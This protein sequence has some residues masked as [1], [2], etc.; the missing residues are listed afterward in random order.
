MSTLSQLYN[1]CE[2]FSVTTT[3]PISPPKKS[4]WRACP[5]WLVTTLTVSALTAGV[6]GT[7]L[8][9]FLHSKPFQKRQFSAEEAA[10]FNKEERIS[11]LAAGLP[12]LTRPVNILVLGTIVLSSD[13]P[14]LANPDDRYFRQIGSDLDGHSDAILLIRFD[15]V[16]QKIAAISIPR[17]TLTLV[18]DLGMTK[19]NTANFVGGAPLAARTVSKLLGGVPIDRYVRVNVQ[20]FN[21][22][23]DALGGVEVYVPK[24]LKYQDD[25]Q[26]LYIN[27]KAGKQVLNGDKAVQ[28]MRF[29]QDDLGDIGRV[30]RQQAFI[31][32]LIEQKLHIETVAKIPEILNILHDNLDTNLTVEEMLALGSFAAKIGRKDTRLLMLPGR[33][34]THEYHLSYWLVNEQAVARMMHEHFDNLIADPKALQP[35][36]LQNLRLAVQDSLGDPQRI[37]ALQNQ[38]MQLGYSQVQSMDNPELPVLPK[39]QIIAQNGDRTSAEAIQ[40][41]LGIGEVVVESTGYIYSD[42]TIRLGKDWQPSP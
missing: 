13:R 19:I 25:S 29:R 35:T 24:D 4:P 10:A 27:L 2:G 22:L 14:A 40:K 12:D 20:G 17:D 8:A 1:W 16:K 36:N 26:R 42:V 3:P 5:K 7:G 6:L 28:Y 34:S 31:R 9:F 15:P 39:T 23:I 11:A 30:Q 18:P 21:Q 41:A 38:L 33:F 37:K 32:A